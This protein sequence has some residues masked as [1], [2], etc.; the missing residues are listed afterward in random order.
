MH[1]RSI[2]TAITA[3][4]V[5]SLTTSAQRPKPAAK[6]GCD[7]YVA[8]RLHSYFSRYSIE[9]AQV[10]NNVDDE[11]N[12][13]RTETIKMGSHTV[14]WIVKN[15]GIGPRASVRI[16]GDLVTLEDKQSLNITD[17]D[18]RLDMKVI[19]EWRQAKL[20][21]L[22]GREVIA[23]TIG[24]E[25]CTGTMCSVGAQLY[26]DTSARRS[27]FF[28]RYRTDHEA[29][30]YRFP[31]DEGVFVIAANFAGDHHLV[32]RPAVVTYKLYRLRPNGEFK[33]EK[34]PSG[35]EYWLRHTEFIEKQAKPDR[36]EQHWIEKLK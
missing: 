19:S 5:L 7:T 23:L 33:I 29:Q 15:E 17:E 35:K 14:E 27:E 18:R 9:A 24:P 3:L 32:T 31:G 34:D 1:M 22:H 26:Y 21:K 13:S 8:E 11:P 28:G 12:T 16:N 6:T 2:A 4:L 25:T 20:Y 36:L 30:L 10:I